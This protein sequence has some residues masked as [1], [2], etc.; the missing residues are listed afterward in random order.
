M[1]EKRE[2]YKRSARYQSIVIGDGSLIQVVSSSGWG[3]VLPSTG[4]LYSRALNLID[5]PEEE[6]EEEEEVKR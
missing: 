5:G 6:E 2:E 1:F 3:S 4:K